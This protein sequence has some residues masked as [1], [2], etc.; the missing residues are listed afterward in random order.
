M[1]ENKT[2]QLKPKDLAILEDY[3]AFKEEEEAKKKAE[4]D[5]ASSGAAAAKGKADPKKDAKKAPA[6]GAVV[7]DDKNAP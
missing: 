7:A 5:G 1:Y 4:K 6:K 3:L 2:D